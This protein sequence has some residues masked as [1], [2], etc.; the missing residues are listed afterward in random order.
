MDRNKVGENRDKVGKDRNKVGEN[1]DIDDV[2]RV[3]SEKGNSFRKNYAIHKI[4]P[5][6]SHFVC[7]QKW[8]HFALICS[9][10]KCEIFAK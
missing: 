2:N 1:R 9:V 5:K 7:S 10:K 3:N 4:W 6:I 8:E